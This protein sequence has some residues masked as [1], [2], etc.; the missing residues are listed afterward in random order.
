MRLKSLHGNNCLIMYRLRCRM[1]KQKLT[2]LLNLSLFLLGAMMACIGNAAITV[3]S[4]NVSM[5]ATN[6]VEQNQ[7]TENTLK[8]MLKKV[9]QPQI[10]NIAESIQRIRPDILILNEFDYIPDLG[11]GLEAFNSRFLSQSQNGQPPISYSYLY[12]APSNTGLL[13]PLDINGDGKIALPQDAYGYGLFP[14]HYGMAILS[15]YPIDTESVKTFQTFLWADMPNAL[16]PKNEDGSWYYDEKVWKELR[17]SSKSHWDVPVLINN[18]TVHLL[19][20]HPTPPVFDGPEDR[21][22]HR[23]FDEIRFLERLY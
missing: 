3:A 11:E 7:A 4:F 12:I 17:L 5:E 13:S 20:S 16:R 9:D 14:G 15:R 22:G 21:N 2:L 8:E 18:K 23:N 10:K 6:Y 19:V 1:I